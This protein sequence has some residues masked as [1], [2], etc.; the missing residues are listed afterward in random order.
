M[1]RLRLALCA[2]LMVGATTVSRAADADNAQLWLTA[3]GRYNITKALRASV[4]MEHRSQSDLFK[5]T[6]RWSAGAG[7]SYK[8]N[9]WLRTGV[10]YKFLYNREGD[11]TTKKGNYIPAYWQSGHR[12]QL[13]A[14]GSMKLGKFELSLREVYQ[15][16][17]YPGQSVPKL[18]ADGDRKKDE[19]I[20]DESKQYLRSRIEAEYVHGKKALVTPYA[21]VELY[22]NL[23]EAMAT[24]KVRY[25]GGASFRINKHNSVAT[26]YRFVDRYGNKANDHVVGVEYLFKF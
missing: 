1:K 6:S 4:E 16:T 5:A 23:D 21:T 18:D 3:E 2:L 20:A 13:S 7:V 17:F 24:S 9:G 11:E 19:V 14:T 12:I 26:Y 15:N 10:N 25:T 8:V 22:S